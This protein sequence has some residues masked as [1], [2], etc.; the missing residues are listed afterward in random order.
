MEEKEEEREQTATSTV[1]SIFD[2][3]P[4]HGLRDDGDNNLHEHTTI[5]EEEESAASLLSRMEETDLRNDDDCSSCCSEDEATLEDHA[6]VVMTILQPVAI[7][8]VLVIWIVKVMN[9]STVAGMDREVVRW[10][11]VY[12]ESGNFSFVD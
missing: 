3:V 4:L 8:M 10:Y 7:T 6:D 1:R 12:H 9:N 2:D 5:E 11:M